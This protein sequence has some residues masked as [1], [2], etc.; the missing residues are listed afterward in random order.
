MMVNEELKEGEHL[1]VEIDLPLL[2]DPIKCTCEVSWFEDF[3][4]GLR[5]R[6][7]SAGDLHK[8]LEFVHM[9]GIG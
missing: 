1:H 3:E 7:I 6:D 5:F 2:E 9:V 8:I 4:V